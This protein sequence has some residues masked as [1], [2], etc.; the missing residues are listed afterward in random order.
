MALAILL[1]VSCCAFALA[2]ALGVR[3]PAELLSAAWAIAIL[4]ILVPTHLLGV[5]GRLDR[6]NLVAATLATCVGAAS[7]A[8]SARGSAAFFVDLRDAAR[9]PFR[10]ARAFPGGLAWPFAAL[11]SWVLLRSL[12]GVVL[13]PSDAWDGIWYHDTIT[14]WAIQ[15][16]GYDPMPLPANLLQQVNGFP[17]NAEMTSAWLVLCSDRTLI[18]LPNAV[19][20]LPLASSSYLLVARFTERRSTAA[21]LALIVALA[22]GCVL[23]LRSTYV[24]VFAAA[25]AA[26]ALHFATKRPLTTRDL[27]LAGL[28][29]SLWLGSKLSALLGAPLVGLVLLVGLRGL[30][31]RHR[32]LAVLSATALPLAAMTLTYGRNAS[33]F[34]N[35]LWPLPVSLPRLGID[36]PGAA[37]SADLEIAA[38][39][40]VTLRSIFLPTT[41][42]LDFADLR[43]GGYGLAI[44]WCVLPAAVVGLGRAVVTAL[45]PTV[46]LRPSLA[47]SE[48]TRA[49]RLLLLTLLVLPSLALS[50]ALWAARYHLAALVA[51]AA[52][53]G[54]AARGAPRFALITHA[55]AACALIVVRLWS[56]EPPLGGASLRDL[57]RAATETSL[58]RA[59]H[60]PATFSLEPAVARAREETLGP[61]SLTVFGAGV[62]FPSVLWNERFDNRI[63]FVPEETPNALARRI[64]ELSPSWIVAG[65]DEPLYRYASERP[66]EWTNLGLASR[67]QPTYAFARAPKRVDPP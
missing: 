37:R 45:R 36:W 7:I 47:I 41:P 10:A 2:R 51:P 56:Y 61:G 57:G 43:S 25:S 22:P 29:L 28:T 67:G 50:P 8:V 27:F 21:T 46:G 40:A 39:L 31:G 32:A 1:S 34:G 20:I 42:G 38:P 49:R 11:L 63:Q 13:L 66:T 52:L 64:A 24:D 33:H 35:P 55:A 4:L 5:V 53:A 6:V 3:R 65:P 59:T 15:S 16:G 30:R 9:F 19:A 26:S 54:Y 62:T 18:E 48:R 60:P 14:G 17:R 23:Q 58:E 12:L 44:A